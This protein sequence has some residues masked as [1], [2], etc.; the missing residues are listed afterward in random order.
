[1]FRTKAFIGQPAPQKLVPST[2]NQRHT[3]K[4]EDCMTKYDGEGIQSI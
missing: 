1:M 3:R 2:E 4:N